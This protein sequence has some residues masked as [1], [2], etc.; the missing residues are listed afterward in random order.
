MGKNVISGLFRLTHTFLN[1]LKKINTIE[2]VK[3]SVF[4]MDKKDSFM[5]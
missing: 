4:M 5:F 2:Y 1:V 3:L